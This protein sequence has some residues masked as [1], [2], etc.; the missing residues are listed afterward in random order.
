[1]EQII[2]RE[3]ENAPQPNKNTE[4]FC[5]T[6]N[7]VFARFIVKLGEWKP[8]NDGDYRMGKD[9]VI[10]KQPRYAPMSGYTAK[11]LSNWLDRQGFVS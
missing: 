8:A 3:G 2:V 4:V 5:P 11:Q 7:G 6:W 1:M 9:G 10:R